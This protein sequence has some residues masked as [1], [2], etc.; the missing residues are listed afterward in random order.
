MLETFIIVA[1]LEIGTI[2]WAL[3]QRFYKVEVQLL[4]TAG[5]RKSVVRP[6]MERWAK[7]GT[8]T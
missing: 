3:S 6:F 4:K 7:Q 5:P 1:T 2:K 8:D